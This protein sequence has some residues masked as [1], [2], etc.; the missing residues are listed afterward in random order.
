MSSVSR[1][2]DISMMWIFSLYLSHST[3]SLTNLLTMALTD[4]FWWRPI[5]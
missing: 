2:G 5:V 1:V 4:I 3:Y